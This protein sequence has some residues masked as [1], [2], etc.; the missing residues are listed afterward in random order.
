MTS[1]VIERLGVGAHGAIVIGFT[2]TA[3][4]LRRDG[5]GDHLKQ[6]PIF[7]I[8]VGADA[9]SDPQ[10]QCLQHHAHERPQ[11]IVVGLG[12]QQ[13]LAAGAAAGA[14]AHQDEL[15]DGATLMHVMLQAWGLWTA[16]IIRSGGYVEDQMMFEVIFEA[17]PCNPCPSSPVVKLLY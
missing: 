1:S 13:L 11:V 15:L 10:A 7:D 5:L 6:H 14:A 17:I 2:A 9:H 4:Q 8:V 16:L 3:D 12:E